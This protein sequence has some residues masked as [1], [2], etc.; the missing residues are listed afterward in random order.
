MKRQQGLEKDL[1][2]A[3]VLSEMAEININWNN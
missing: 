2:I 3:L 1:V